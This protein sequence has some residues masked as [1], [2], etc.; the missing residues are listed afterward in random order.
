M[1]S[2]SVMEEGKRVLSGHKFDE[3]G[4]SAH[5][6]K[7]CPKREK[8][9]A[10]IAEEDEAPVEESTSRVNPLQLLNSIRQES[11]SDTGLMLVFVKVNGQV[12]RAM[13]DTGATHNFLSDWIV[14]R[15]GLRVDKENSKGGEL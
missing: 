10:L 5:R 15:L 4:R 9:N 2:S 8:V 13:V 14:A 6:A 12:V 7:Q 3:E 1:G 11:R